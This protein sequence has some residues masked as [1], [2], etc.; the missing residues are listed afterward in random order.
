MSTPIL[1]TFSARAF[2]WAT[3]LEKADSALRAWIDSNMKWSWGDSGKIVVENCAKL[4]ERA[5]RAIQNPQSYPTV[6]RFDAEVK[7]LVSGIYLQIRD[8]VPQWTDLA[9]DTAGDVGDL[10]KPI[11]TWGSA[12]IGFGLVAV[13]AVYLLLW[14]R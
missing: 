14:K 10:A 1:S 9:K 7:A 13:A 11:A 4:A 6:E 3:E 2:Y 12:G 8:P 5:R